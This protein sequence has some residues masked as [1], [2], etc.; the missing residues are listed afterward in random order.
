MGKQYYEKPLRIFIA[1]SNQDKIAK[2]VIATFKKLSRDSVQKIEVITFPSVRARHKYFPDLIKDAIGDVDI[3]VGVLS[4][5][6]RRNQWVNQEVGF[7]V[8]K[9]KDMLLIAESKD[10]AN[11][12][13]GFVNINV[14]DVL[15]TES[16]LEQELKDWLEKFIGDKQVE[17]I[18]KEFT[19]LLINMRR[20]IDADI[21]L[22]QESRS[23]NYISY[24]EG[25][26]RNAKILLDGQRENGFINL[27]QLHNLKDQINANNAANFQ[28]SKLKTPFNNLY[29]LYSDER[30]NQ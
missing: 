1:H 21:L 2:E 23:S 7:A 19:L 10:G 18:E 17:I 11:K 6:G 16:D 15:S 8:A 30:K 26:E 3:F 4:Q 13:S 20:I 9:N 27:G 22:A 25:I 5:A 24:L 29:S 12:I 28:I 14:H